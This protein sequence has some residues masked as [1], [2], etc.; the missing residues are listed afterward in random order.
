MALTA[1]VMKQHREDFKAAGCDDFLTKPIDQDELRGVL[2]RYLSQIS[3]PPVNTVSD[4]SGAI[5]SKI[6]EQL[7][8]VFVERMS[9][10][11]GELEQALSARDWER[12]HGAAHNIKGS[13]A[14]Y[15]YPRLSELGS[16][17]CDEIVVKQIGLL[18]ELVEQLIVEIDQAL[19]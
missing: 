4:A 16:E 5:D 1:N 19:V 14:P 13:A 9:A 12:L 15:G 17:I 3:T 2:Q 11:R 10:L 18:P 8:P 6:L 7:R